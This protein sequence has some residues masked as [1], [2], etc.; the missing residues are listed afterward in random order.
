MVFYSIIANESA[1]MQC[2]YEKEEIITLDVK[3]TTNMETVYSSH[4]F[5][6]F[7]H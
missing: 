4:N 5:I 2:V 1:E 6:V 3:E 7:V